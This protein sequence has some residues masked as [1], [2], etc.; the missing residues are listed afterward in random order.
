MKTLVLKFLRRDLL[1]DACV[2]VEVLAAG[3]ASSGC[4]QVP[5]DAIPPTELSD[6]EREQIAHIVRGT[7]EDRFSRAG[8]V[9]EIVQWVELMS[10][11]RI[12]SKGDIEQLN[13]G[14]EFAL[15]RLHCISGRNYWFKA[16]GA[17][18]RHERLVT[19][20]LTRLDI[21]S[22]P[23]VIASHPEWNAWLMQQFGCRINKDLADPELSES[24]LGSAVRSISHLQLKTVGRAGELCRAGVFD[25]S[26][27]TMRL[28]SNE[29]FD[30]IDY[31]MALQASDKAPRLDRRRVRQLMEIFE[32]CCDLAN[33]YDLPETINHGDLNLGNLVFGLNGCQFIDW[34]EAYWGYPLCSLQ[35]LLLLNK[36]NDD[37]LRVK[38]NQQ[39]ITQYREVWSKNLDYRIL[40]DHVIIM[41]IMAIMSTL[42]GRG[43]WQSED[44]R[45]DV[46]RQA[47]TRTV[48]R[49]MDRA[50]RDPLL[51]ERL[52]L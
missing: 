26:V 19:E 8:W 25:Q 7:D 43:D 45:D 44:W 3:S 22:V 31:A 1:E 37:A 12:C 46:G 20:A 4:I 32:R 21:Q 17:P 11:D 34:S 14:G 50:A 13:A 6:V 29:L 49:C 42:Y 16:T 41:P 15:L 27:S 39:L 47:Y 48:A 52:A 9:K 28:H 24:M 40:D 5:L 2:V 38:L 30:Y 23:A 10:G 35:H 18:N 51:L 33:G 36:V